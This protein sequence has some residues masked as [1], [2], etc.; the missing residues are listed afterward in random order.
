[1]PTIEKIEDF[2]AW[3]KSRE[4]NKLIHKIVAD[5]IF[6]PFPDLRHQMKKSSRSVMGNLAEGL[7]RN[8][9]KEFLN[10][11][12]IAS[13]SLMEL[14]SDTHASFDLELL[15]KEIYVEILALIEQVDKLSN[16]MRR[17]L[18]SNIKK[19]NNTLMKK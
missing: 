8:S 3:V 14:K 9:N 2:Q 15:S 13:G 5:K 11:I 10:F 1:M 7:S 18:I 4:L 17:Y 16:G 6:D 19:G 12:S